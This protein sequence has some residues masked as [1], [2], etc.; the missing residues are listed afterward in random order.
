MNNEVVLSLKGVHKAYAQGGRSVKVLQGVN[1]DLCKGELVA[2]VAPSGAGKSTLLH[3]A[4]LMDRP[5]TGDVI[6]AGQSSAQMR[7]RRLTHMRRYHVGF[8]F[9]FHHLLSEFTALENVMMPM[10][11]ARIEK[12]KAQAKAK[13]LLKR[14]GLGERLDH[15]PNQ[16]SGGE[17]QRVAFARSLA[18]DPAIILAD[19]P[20]GSLD[21]KT[22]DRIFDQMLEV[23]REQG[24]GVLV[25]THNMALATR[26]D[27]TITLEDGHIVAHDSV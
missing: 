22:A 7:D 26:M 19:E 3:V 18:N 12:N 5:D 13:K 10:L 6:V 11:I 21:P 2:F 23:A 24:V 14:V 15:K 1:F 17:Q 8:M 16:L 9:Q 25:A 27:R 20:T 4:G